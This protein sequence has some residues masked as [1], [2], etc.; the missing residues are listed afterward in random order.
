MYSSKNVEGYYSSQDKRQ[1]SVLKR[2]RRRP[3]EFVRQGK[4]EKIQRRK[5][6][7]SKSLTETAP[8]ETLPERPQRPS[9]PRAGR[10]PTGKDRQ[11]DS[12]LHQ[13]SHADSPN[14]KGSESGRWQVLVSLAALPGNLGGGVAPCRP[15]RGP[16]WRP[17]LP[18][19]KDCV[20]EYCE[21]KT[22]RRGRSF[23]SK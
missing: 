13:G 19:P 10:A 8:Q 7:R 21:E 22:G 6:T 9:D 17:L 12:P 23:L 4:E 14:K 1:A 15:P 3:T 20:A 2:R 18:G 16:A 11:T 5:L